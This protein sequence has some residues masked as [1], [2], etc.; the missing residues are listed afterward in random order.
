MGQHLLV[1]VLWDLASEID[2]VVDDWARFQRLEVRLRAGTKS[3]PRGFQ[4]FG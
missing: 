2:R 4:V 3:Q 1:Q